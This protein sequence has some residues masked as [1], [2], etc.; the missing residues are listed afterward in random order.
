MSRSGKFLTRPEAVSG[1]KH[2]S[3]RPRA[4]QSVTGWAGE[5]GRPGPL[6][7][8]HVGALPPY[9]ERGWAGAEAETQGTRG[10]PRLGLKGDC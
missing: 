5:A 1:Q 7:S 3:Y 6:D 8:P 9:T 2:T 10:G 4:V